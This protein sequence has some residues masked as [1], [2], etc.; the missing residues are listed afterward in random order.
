MHF[1]LVANCVFVANE[2]VEEW[3]IYNQAS[4]I[5]QLG[6]DVLGRA[7][8]LGGSL[9]VGRLL[10]GFGEPD[11]LLGQGKPAHLPPQKTDGFD[12]EY[13]LRS[14]FHYVWNWRMLGRISEVYAPDLRFY[15][16]SDRELY[17]RGD[18]QAFVLSLLAMFPDLSLQT[19][20]LYWMG[21]DAEGYVTSTRWSAVGSHRGHGVYGPPTGRRVYMWGIT[22]HVVRGGK[23]T[24]EWMMFNELGVMATLFGD[25][26]E[27]QPEQTPG[28]TETS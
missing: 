2:N 28:R 18:Y 13:F 12:V 23:I 9:D 15:G 6:L 20:D 11:R 17:G 5:K 4:L 25:G 3:V 21:N 16:P 7:R 10:E 24:E 14:T 22:Q 19:D 26:L 1:W 8:E 27:P